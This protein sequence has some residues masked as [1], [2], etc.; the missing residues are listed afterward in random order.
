[1]EREYDLESSLAH[2]RRV[3][4]G[5]LNVTRDAEDREH[6][7]QLYEMLTASLLESAQDA[8]LRLDTQPREQL[9]AFEERLGGPPAGALPINVLLSPP[10][11]R[12]EVGPAEVH[13]RAVL[14][15]AV[16]AS[17]AAAVASADDAA[18]PDYAQY[19]RLDEL[20]N[21]LACCDE[22]ES[23]DERLADV[24]WLYRE[25]LSAEDFEAIDAAERA[26]G[27]PPAGVEP[28]RAFLEQA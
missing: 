1:M 12:L 14:D 4:A 2:A 7:A 19:Y 15:A 6:L 9:T 25:T 27:G 10:E 5:R 11:E 18:S 3:V 8:Y 28:V 22:P 16:E 20:R 13:A 24:R 21:L 23:R 26:L 17:R